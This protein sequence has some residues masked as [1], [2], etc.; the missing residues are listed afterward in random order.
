MGSA[1]LKPDDRGAAVVLASP[2]AEPKIAGGIGDVGVL[3]V[4]FVIGHVLPV[5]AVD[6][7]LKRDDG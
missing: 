7:A 3:E 1:D 2:H 5:R 6:I 4:A